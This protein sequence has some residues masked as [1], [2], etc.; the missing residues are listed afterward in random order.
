MKDKKTVSLIIAIFSVVIIVIAG[1][2]VVQ[3]SKEPDTIDTAQS[4]AVQQEEDGQ[5]G[6]DKTTEEAAEFSL[7]EIQG[8]AYYNS[9]AGI[10]FN[11][12]SDDWSFLDAEEAARLVNAK[13]SKSKPVY[14]N[15]YGKL[16]YDACILDKKTKTSIQLALF[17]SNEKKN[18]NAKQIISMLYKRQKN[19]Y[20][21]FSH[22]D[23]YEL[24]VAGSTYLCTDCVYT[25]NGTDKRYTI[26]TRKIGS[27]FVCITTDL[28]SNNDE[29]LSS[30]Y[31]SIFREYKV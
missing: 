27:D 11:L 3:E 23:F 5:S 26:A 18:L 28:I 17:E 7:G 20:D 31:L 13:V 10:M 30:D 9:F 4:S 1:I 22:G 19:M 15:H 14:S 29:N 16:Y 8:N 2:I 25:N 24:Q 12:P 21:D 6:A